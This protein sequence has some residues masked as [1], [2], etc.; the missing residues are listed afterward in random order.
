MLRVIAKGG[1]EVACADGAALWYDLESPDEGEERDVEVSLGIDVPTPAERAAFEESA[2][3]YEEGEALHLTATL[4]GRRD[5]G[6]LV[7]GAVTFIL[8]KGKLVTVRQVR[9][10]AFEI[11]QGR[12]S[13]R[14]GSAQNGAD[15]MLALIEGAAERLADLLAEAKRDANALSLNVFATEGAPDLEHS[16]RELGR[17]GALAALSHDSLSSMQRLL[18]YARAAK[19]KHNLDAARLAALA[20]DV[21]E[22]E[23][24]AENM[25]PRLSFLQDALLGLINASQTNV[26]KALSLATI[27]FVPPTL[28][29]S[30]FGMNFDAM[31]WFRQPWGPWVG[32]AMMIAAPAIL[33]GIAKW[34]RWF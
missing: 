7:S 18:V 34:R 30:I 26:L 33:F 5:E 28:I 21:N 25:Q 19:G 1:S 13:A 9:P 17:I 32:V 20:R 3:Y 22:L 15:V 14:I 16:L 31:T 24:I 12:A 29:A 6:L 2:R 4:L 23:R 27:A 11:G 8:A 10:R